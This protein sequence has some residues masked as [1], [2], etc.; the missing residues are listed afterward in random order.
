MEDHK[1]FGKGAALSLALASSRKLD[2]GFEVGC[3][4]NIIY[5]HANGA[6]RKNTFHRL[7][8]G[9]WAFVLLHEGFDVPSQAMKDDAQREQRMRKSHI[10]HL[11]EQQQQ[12]RKLHNIH[13]RKR[14]RY[15]LAQVD[16]NPENPRPGLAL[17]DVPQYLKQVMGDSLA[18]DDG[19][20]AEELGKW[21]SRNI[22]A[23]DNVEYCGEGEVEKIVKKVYADNYKWELVYFPQ[24]KDSALR[25]S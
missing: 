22:A 18:G 11:P 8:S 9:Q 6:L 12:S 1:Q 4:S 16:K 10:P 13:G 7:Q 25:Q 15:A 5:N 17:V 20:T 3:L 24:N 23:I 19:L 21:W 14:V 2:A